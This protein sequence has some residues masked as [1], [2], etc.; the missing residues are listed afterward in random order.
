MGILILEFQKVLG[1]IQKFYKN[2]WTNN[3]NWSLMFCHKEEFGNLR[4]KV[5]IY[6]NLIFPCFTWIV[7][8]IY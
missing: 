4:I 6:N 8:S 2:N 1:M 5:N 7:L 3:N